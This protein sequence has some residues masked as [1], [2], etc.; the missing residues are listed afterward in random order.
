MVCS[1]TLLRVAIRVTARGDRTMA[2]LHHV[3]LNEIVTHF[4][5]LEDPRSSVNRKHP[6]C[7]V[8]VIAASRHSIGGKDAPCFGLVAQ[9]LRRVGRRAKQNILPIGRRL[10]LLGAG[11]RQTHDR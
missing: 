3:G 7:S 10:C 6:L 8:V 9:H 11:C 4:E 2:A 5:K 1:Y